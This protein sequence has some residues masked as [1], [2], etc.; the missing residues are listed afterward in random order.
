MLAY[1]GPRWSELSGLR[2]RDLAP[3][4]KHLRC[5]VEHTVVADRGYQRIEPPKDYEHRSIPIPPF[6]FGP[7]R[8]QI[9]GR[10]GDAR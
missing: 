3:D 8:A 5:T 2:I 1:C 9:A 4:A 6:L 10:E 7:L